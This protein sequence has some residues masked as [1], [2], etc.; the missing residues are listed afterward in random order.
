[1]RLTLE[2]WLGAIAVGAGLRPWT[3]LYALRKKVGGRLRATP[4]RIAKKVVPI[5]RSRSYRR[6]DHRSRSLSARSRPIYAMT[7]GKEANSGL[8]FIAKARTI[9]SFGLSGN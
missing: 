9:K 7:E 2:R 6:S 8:T 5:S 4:T 1:M 3:K